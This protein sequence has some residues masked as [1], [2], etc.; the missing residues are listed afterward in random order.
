MGLLWAFIALCYVIRGFYG[1][2]FKKMR[3]VAFVGATFDDARGRD[4]T[5]RIGFFSL[6]RCVRVS[7]LCARV[8]LVV[9]SSS[10]RRRHGG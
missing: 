9:V 5:Q 3:F 6:G 8:R 1:K 4:D 10:G 2:F 7:S